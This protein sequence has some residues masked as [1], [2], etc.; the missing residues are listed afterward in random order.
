MSDPY[1]IVPPKVI[2]VTIHWGEDED[3]RMI[4]YKDDTREEFEAA[5]AEIVD[6]FG[7]C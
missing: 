1:P 6:E 7:G 2:V 3:G 5:L 4:V